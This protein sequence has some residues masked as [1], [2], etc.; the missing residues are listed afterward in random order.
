MV[1]HCV[2][3]LP[4]STIGST[5]ENGRVSVLQY[6]ET[7]GALHFYVAVSKDQI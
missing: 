1:L 7:S 6:L 5:E 2:G 3:D 4:A